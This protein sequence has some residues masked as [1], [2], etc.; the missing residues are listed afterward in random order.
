MTPQAALIELLGRLAANR[1]EAVY[2]GNDE[3]GLWPADAVAALKSSGLIAMASPATSTECPGCERA[4]MRPVIGLPELVSSTG[5]AFVVCDVRNDI[6]RVA[7]E[8]AS[9][10]RWKSSG[11]MLAELVARLLKFEPV[12]VSVLEGGGRWRVGQ[13]AGRKHKSPLVLTATDLTGPS[14]AVAGHVVM[15][16]DVLSI[17]NAVISIDSSALVR[18][19]DSPKGQ[20][21]KESETPKQR[22]ERILRRTNELQAQGVKPFLEVVAK[23]EGISSDRI[24]QIRAAAKKK[25]RQTVFSGLGKQATRPSSKKSQS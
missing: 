2:I 20:E 19:V 24:K 9:L 11:L 7:I 15:A 5:A 14:L 4:C 12:V 23:E 10:E 3:L 16:V 22:G 8:P 6:N 18:L 1:G 17:K 13:L 25:T 21:A